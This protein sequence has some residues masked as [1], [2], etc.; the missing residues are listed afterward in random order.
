MLGEV[1]IEDKRIQEYKI[2][3]EDETLHQ[4]DYRCDYRADFHWNVRVP[5]A[6]EPAK[7]RR[8]SGVYA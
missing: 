6:E 4:T 3:K 8:L 5:L 7:A 1:I 2:E